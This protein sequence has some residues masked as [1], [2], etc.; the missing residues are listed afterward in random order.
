MIYE[1]RE[2]RT[3]QQAAE[4][5]N[6]HHTTVS[7]WIAGRERPTSSSVIQRVAGKVGKPYKE[8]AAAISADDERKGA[9]AF[10]RTAADSDAAN[11]ENLRVLGRLVGVRPE[12]LSLL[13]EKLVV[14]LTELGLLEDEQVPGAGF[15]PGAGAPPRSSRRPK[16]SP[17]PGTTPPPR[18]ARPKKA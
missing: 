10:E 15:V 3:V 2:S 14:L 7:R 11:E 1:Y 16:R 9:Q 12:K 17:D 4:D 6:V 8:V 5:F 18:R 13:F